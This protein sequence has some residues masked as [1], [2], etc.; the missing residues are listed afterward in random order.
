[1]AQ[2]MIRSQSYAFMCWSIGP[3]FNVCEPVQLPRG[4]PFGLLPSSLPSVIVV[5]TFVFFYVGKILVF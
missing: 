2:V 4:R 1:M 5:S 3:F